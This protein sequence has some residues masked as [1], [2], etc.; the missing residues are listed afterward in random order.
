MH[1]ATGRILSRTMCRDCGVLPGQ[2][3]SETCGTTARLVEAGS[4]IAFRAER[5]QLERK[6]DHVVEQLGHALDRGERLLDRLEQLE[7]RTK[8][9]R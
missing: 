9:G 4:V 6:L 3:H 5:E 8:A 7:K 2:Y 1:E